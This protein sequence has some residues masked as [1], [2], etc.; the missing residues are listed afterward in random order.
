M[1]DT[2]LNIPL[3]QISNR[4]LPLRQRTD[5]NRLEDLVYSIQRY[6]VIEPIVVTPSDDGYQ[7]VIGRRR[8]EAC[9]KLG[10]ETVPAVVRRMSEERARELSY[11]SN[12]Q[13]QPLNIADEVD[14]LRRIDIFHLKDDEA[15]RRLAMSPQEVAVARRF[16][17]LPP[18]I[19]EAVRT[20]EID[21]RRALALTRLAGEADQIRMFRYIREN[22]PSIELLEEQIDRVRDG[23]APHL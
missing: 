10:L 2:Y 19:R 11:Q 20:G 14:F 13:I 16:S 6:G 1:A 12:L 7:L 18:A 23:E 4:K 17:R 15:A 9:Q 8:F 3:D 22:D 21:E 5:A